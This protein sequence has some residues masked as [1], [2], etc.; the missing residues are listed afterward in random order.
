MLGCQDR[1]L[2]PSSSE[3]DPLGAV[4]RVEGVWQGTEGRGWKDSWQALVEGVGC[5]LKV[6][7]IFS[8]VGR[9]L[10]LNG[11]IFNANCFLP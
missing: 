5:L 2:G 7:E 8:Q 1:L 3:D 11:A 9:A 10:I 6:L 4:A